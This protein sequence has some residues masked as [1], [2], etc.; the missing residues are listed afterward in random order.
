MVRAERNLLWYETF[1]VGSHK[2]FGNIEDANSDVSIFFRLFIER[3]TDLNYPSTLVEVVR[4][5][6]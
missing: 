3:L 4:L 2:D 5:R 1:R 6:A